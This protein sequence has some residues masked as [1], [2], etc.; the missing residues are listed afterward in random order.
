MKRR[1]LKICLKRRLR[2]KSL[3]TIVLATRALDVVLVT[4]QK[5][6]KHSCLTREWPESSS[7]DQVMPNPLRRI[8][9]HNLDKESF[10]QVARDLKQSLTVGLNRSM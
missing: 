4:Y 2:S 7:K 10:L 8:Y 3:W 1:S 5:I 6:W 9:L